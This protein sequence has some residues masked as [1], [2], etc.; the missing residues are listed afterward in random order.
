MAHEFSDVLSIQVLDQKQIEVRR[1]A[2]LANDGLRM[3]P[4]MDT[5]LHLR[6]S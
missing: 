5:N 6:L 3:G 1:P 2:F 4:D